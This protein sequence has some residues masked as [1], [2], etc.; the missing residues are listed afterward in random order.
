[1]FSERCFLVKQDGAGR[2]QTEIDWVMLAY[3]GYIK[4][5]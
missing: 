2:G 4:V 1:M 3:I 5:T